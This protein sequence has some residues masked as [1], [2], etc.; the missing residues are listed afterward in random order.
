[1]S[2]CWL[3]QGKANGKPARIC[4]GC[5]YYAGRKSGSINKSINCWDHKKCTEECKFRNPAP[6][7]N[8]ET[9]Q[10]RTKLLN[11]VNKYK[12]MN[13]KRKKP[14]K[15]KSVELSEKGSKLIA[16]AIKAMLRGKK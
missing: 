9:E 10:S 4:Y 11:T 8:V 7:N 16:Q 15:V 6:Q 1:M 5:S 3:F 14:Q 2:E 12:R 13:A